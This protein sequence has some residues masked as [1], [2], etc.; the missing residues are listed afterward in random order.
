MVA[1]FPLYIYNLFMCDLQLAYHLVEQSQKM[2]YHLY[3]LIL[4]NFFST[5]IFLNVLSS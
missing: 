2:H 3:L 1:S 5:M 4:C